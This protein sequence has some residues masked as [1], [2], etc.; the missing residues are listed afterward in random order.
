MAH[1]AI[2]D[3][4]EGQQPWY[5]LLGTNPENKQAFCEASIHVTFYKKALQFT[6]IQYFR[7]N[8]TDTRLNLLTNKV[9]NNKNGSVKPNRE[10]EHLAIAEFLKLLKA[11]I[12][13]EGRLYNCKDGS[14]TLSKTTVVIKQLNKREVLT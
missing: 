11:T 8:T 6:T 9:S 3:H 12:E 14:E 5:G 2:D 4:V 1:K 10:T 7:N 13:F